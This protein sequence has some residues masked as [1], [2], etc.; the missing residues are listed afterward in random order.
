M[1]RMKTIKTQYRPKEAPIEI[2]T[3]E[4]GSGAVAA[5]TNQPTAIQNEIISPA[6]SK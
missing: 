2:N 6:R 4:R 1:E 3:P 5:E